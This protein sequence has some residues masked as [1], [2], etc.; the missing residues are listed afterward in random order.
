[1]AGA[2]GGIKDANRRTLSRGDDPGLSSGPSGIPRVL[3]SARGRQE[4]QSQRDVAQER[5]DWPL[6][7]LKVED[8]TKEGGWPVA[9]DKEQKQI[10]SLRLQKKLSPAP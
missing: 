8:G 3:L 1:M 7:V 9:A 6:L 10:L 2:G 5:P 4:G